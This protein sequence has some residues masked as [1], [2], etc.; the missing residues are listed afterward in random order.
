MNVYDASLIENGPITRILLDEKAFFPGETISGGVLLTTSRAISFF[1]IIIRMEQ[2]KIYFNEKY[3]SRNIIQEQR[4]NIP[5]QYN[6]YNTEI[7]SLAPS[8][9]TFPFTMQLDSHLSPT[10]ELTEKAHIFIIEYQISTEIYSS[11]KYPIANETIRIKS[12]SIYHPEPLHQSSL[13]N[14]QTWGLNDMGTTILTLSYPRNNYEYLEEVP[15]SLVINNRRCKLDV[16]HLKIEL[17]RHVIVYSQSQKKVEESDSVLLL[18]K[19]PLTCLGGQVKQEKFAI[20]IEDINSNLMREGRLELYPNQKRKEVF[21]GSVEDEEIKCRYFIKVTCYF[22][23][24]VPFKLR[25]R[26]I[27]PLWISSKVDNNSHSAINHHNVNSEEMR[28]V[29]EAMKQSRIEYEK[30]KRRQ[31]DISDIDEE[32]YMIEQMNRIK[33]EEKNNA[34]KKSNND[35]VPLIYECKN[36]RDYLANNDYNLKGGDYEH[37]YNYNEKDNELQKEP[38]ISNKEVFE[39]NRS[40]FNQ[41]GLFESRLTPLVK[42]QEKEKKDNNIIDI[43]AL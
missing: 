3:E 12:R 22:S 9:Y 4:V 17:H 15:L 43:N 36:N 7:V 35:K 6:P 1:N 30:M 2:I 16:D 38:F 13:V 25:P 40:I 33:N 10:L 42:E 24:F 5:L 19:A 11:I 41:E 20:K 29:E 21:I 31:N 18:Y 14:V 37:N 28:D 34:Y 32:L 27:L 39:H 8:S 26:V 23:S